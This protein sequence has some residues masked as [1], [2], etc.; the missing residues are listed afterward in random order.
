MEEWKFLL[1]KDGDRSW[2]PLDSTD[3]EILE[4]RYRVVAHS[5]QPNADISI[6]I[7]HLA[8][9][10]DPPKRRI[11]KRSNRT[12]AGGLMVVIPF[13]H[14]Q[15]GLWEISCLSADPMSDLL[16]D[17]LHHSIRLQVAACVIED[18][19]DWD[20]LQPSAEQLSVEQPSLETE[21]VCSHTPPDRAIADSPASHQSAPTPRELAALNVE[22]AQALG[23]SM[24]RLMEMAEEI[25]HQL[26]EEVFREFNLAAIPNTPA[27]ATPEPSSSE[28]SAEEAV[29]NPDRSNTEPNPEPEAAT[30]PQGLIDLSTLRIVLDQDVLVVN[31]DRQ[32]LVLSGR[33]EVDDSEPD[34]E[35]ECRQLKKT[36]AQEIQVCL[37][38]PQ[39]SKVLVSDRQVLSAGTP[40]L[41]FTFSLSLPTDLTTRLVLGEVLLCGTPSEESQALVTLTSQ[42]F[43]ITVDPESLVEELNRV[44]AALADSEDSENSSNL[45]AQFHA[46]LLKGRNRP[47]LDLSFLKLTAPRLEQSSAAAEEGVLP[48]RQ[49]VATATQVLPPQLYQPDLDLASKRQVELPRFVRIQPELE[50]PSSEVSA[51]QEET[52]GFADDLAELESMILSE[53]VLLEESVDSVE[54]ADSADSS[55]QTINHS[56]EEPISCTFEEDSKA[57]EDEED[58]LEEPVNSAI[59]EDGNAINSEADA[60]VDSAVQDDPDDL[61]FPTETAFQALRL[62]DRFLNRLSSLA[63]DTELSTLLKAFVPPVESPPAQEPTEEP[64]QTPPAL[65]T[66][67]AIAPE[68][69]ATTEEVMADD[70]L[71]WQHYIQ[72]VGSQLNRLPIELNRAVADSSPEPVNPLVLPTDQ[73]VPAPILEAFVQDI[74]AGKPINLRIKL[75]DVQPKIYVKLWVNDRQT[76][77]LLDGPRWLVDFLPNGFGELETATQLTAPLGSLEV[78]LE[79]IAVEMHTQRESQKVSLDCKVLPPDLPEHFLDE[80][81]ELKMWN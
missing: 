3:I 37:R 68:T 55:V 63:A 62:H 32:P 33:L 5:G 78:R 73:P 69:P 31:R 19:E 9:E 56:V 64:A 80:L 7:C 25:S 6:R 43:A 35:H 76:R 39:S 18:S 61:Q 34:A 24:D 44:H 29:A 74:V 14:L 15:P 38:D 53:P 46:E 20:T 49:A 28:S 81:E 11:Q 45:T 75:P 16:G 79:A 23:L 22:I 8:T 4:G 30:D 1:Q 52:A 26:I 2:L 40:P 54:S 36:V 50:F 72:R 47:L 77:S 42:S 65:V 41:A 27:S 21:E 10:E 12:S 48:V 70:D 51:V 66:C 58:R 57:T 60:E 71:A 67:E 13:T 17:T 59:G